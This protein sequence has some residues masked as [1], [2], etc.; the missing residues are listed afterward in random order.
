MRAI[1]WT[2]DSGKAQLTNVLPGEDTMN[3]RLHRIL[4]GAGILAGGLVCELDCLPDNT[5][6]SWYKLALVQELPTERM[7]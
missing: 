4:C 1:N 3:T 5:H 7:G 6:L 2:T